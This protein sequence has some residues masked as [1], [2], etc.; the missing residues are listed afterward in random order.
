MIDDG[1][2][3][4]CKSSPLSYANSGDIFIYNSTLT[5]ETSQLFIPIFIKNKSNDSPS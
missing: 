3:S 1:F 2:N 5:S 4:E